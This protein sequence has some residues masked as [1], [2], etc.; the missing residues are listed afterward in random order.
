MENLFIRRN[1]LTVLYIL[2]L[3]FVIGVYFDVV[4]S[5]FFL[6]LSVSLTSI[7]IITLPVIKLLG[8]SK[9]KKVPNKIILFGYFLLFGIIHSYINLFYLLRNSK[10][11]VTHIMILFICVCISQIIFFKNKSNENLR[12]VNPFLLISFILI[13]IIHFLL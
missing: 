11:D 3:L 8:F 10:V 6:L 12:S 1:T 4:A 2:S 7:F 9:Y 5:S 13:I